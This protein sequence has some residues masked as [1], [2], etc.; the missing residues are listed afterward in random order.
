MINQE[1]IN[2]INNTGIMVNSC[3]HVSWFAEEE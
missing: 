1:A 2:T 3:H